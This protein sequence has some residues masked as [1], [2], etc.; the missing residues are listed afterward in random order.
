MLHSG[1]A[2]DLHAG[3]RIADRDEEGKERLLRY[4]LRPPLVLDRLSIREDGRVV[5]RLKNTW[6]DDYASYCTSSVL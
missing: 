6:R 3:V 1:P 5:L 2:E 4:L